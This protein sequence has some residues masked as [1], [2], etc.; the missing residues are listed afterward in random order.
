MIRILVVDQLRLFRAGIAALLV[1]EGMT[2]VGEAIDGPTAIAAAAALKP[3]VV[4]LELAVRDNGGLAATRAITADGSRSRILALSTHN[5]RDYL[6]QAIRAGA[7]GYLLKDAE[8]SELLHAVRTV[9]QGGKHVALDAPTQ[10]LP[11]APDAALTPRQREVLQHIAQGRSTREIAGLLTV[12]VKTVETHRAQL[13]DKT[14][15]RDVAGLVRLAI[16][17]GLAGL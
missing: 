3:D 12:S 9:S 1:A 6:S 11:A 14:K 5:A 2:V 10:S 16:R 7:S 8:P 15:I 4:I 13:M 17:M